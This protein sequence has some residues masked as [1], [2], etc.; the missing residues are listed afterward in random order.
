MVCERT[1][2]RCLL[3]HRMAQ[4]VPVKPIDA[5]RETGPRLLDGDNWDRQFVAS[6]HFTERDKH[7]GNPSCCS[8]ILGHGDAALLQACETG[9]FDILPLR[10]GS[11]VFSGSKTPYRWAIVG[12][13]LVGFVSAVHYVHPDKPPELWINE[14]GVGESHRG[15]SIGKRLHSRLH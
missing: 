4:K 12:G 7:H 11:G 14:V 15:Q 9:V 6:S 5:Y 2:A 8:Y 10:V 1:S 13:A 3:Q